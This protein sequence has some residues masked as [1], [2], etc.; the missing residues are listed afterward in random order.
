MDNKILF[1][2][3]ELNKPLTYLNK[4]GKLIR[5]EGWNL[6]LFWAKEYTHENKPS[7]NYKIDSAKILIIR[8]PLTF[9]SSPRVRKK[10]QETIKKDKKNMLIMYS[11]TERDSLDALSEFLKPFMITP[12]EVQII[13][14][15][16]NQDNFRNVIFHKKNKCF[17][18]SELFKG[19]SKILIPHPHLVSVNKPAKILIKGNPSTEVQEDIYF[20]TSTL[21]GSDVIVGA[22]Y[23]DT[24]RILVMDSTLFLDNFFDFNKKF[25]KNVIT[26]LG[27]GVGGH[28]R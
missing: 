9:L 23:D 3:F 19:I 5:D 14:N 26:W 15:K 2:D 22:Y 21:S 4:F 20:E 25:I 7:V 27:Y 16:S 18:H 28:M 24:G 13:D 6:D 10:L 17:N 12:S 1:M 8:K 11:F